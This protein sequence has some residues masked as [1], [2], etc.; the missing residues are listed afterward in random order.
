MENNRHVLPIPADVLAEV[1][2][3]IA[4]AMT[5]LRPY[6]LPLT[7]TERHD[8]PK[9]GDKTLSFVEK[10]YEFAEANPSLRPSFIDM[11]TFQVD[12]QDA[13]G[14]RVVGNAALQLY[15]SISDTEMLSGSEA[16]QTSLG[17]YNNVKL[18]AAQD[19][20]GAKAVYEELKKR[21]HRPKRG[22]GEQG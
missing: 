3:H 15:E 12:M 18:L 11:T 8:I 4:A 19:V 10:S 20:P 7:P 9:M 1:R 14:L 21:F 5:A 2:T 22:G 13:T 16:Y 17:F 6:V